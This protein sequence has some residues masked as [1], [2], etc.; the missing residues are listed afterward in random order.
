MI[1]IDMSGC[2]P[3]LDPSIYQRTGLIS[4]QSQ[5]LSP[6]CE[7]IQIFQKVD[8]SLNIVKRIVTSSL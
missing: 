1:S 2:P 3:Y 8:S 6:K 5:M 4:I 7:M